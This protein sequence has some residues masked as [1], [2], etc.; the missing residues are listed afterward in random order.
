MSTMNLYYPSVRS[1]ARQLLK[2]VLIVSF[3]LSITA[4]GFHL[5]DNY[6]V[7]DSMSE[8]RVSAPDFSEFADALEERLELAGVTLVD[9]A[10]ALTVR[11]VND[12]LDRRALSLSSS[13]QVAEYE[14]IYSV[15]Y[16]LQRPDQDAETFQLEVYRDYQDDPNF[17]LAKT[18][19][20]ELLVSEMRNEAARR[21]VARLINVLTESP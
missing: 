19:E 16:E 6:Q 12:Q 4:C 5:R 18:R 17:V 7:P 9:D 13:G 1:Y 10:N 14:L 11:V 21:T 15:T 8:M 20:R 3:T 2:S